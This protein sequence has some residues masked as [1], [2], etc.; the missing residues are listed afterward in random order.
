MTNMSDPTLIK[1]S[2]IGGHGGSGNGG[3]GIHRR[4]NAIKGAV[5]GHNQA[6]HTGHHGGTYRLGHAPPD[7]IGKLTIKWKPLLKKTYL[8]SMH[9]MH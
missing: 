9:L 5:G 3:G 2:Q 7:K 8:M 1:G 4:M 6:N